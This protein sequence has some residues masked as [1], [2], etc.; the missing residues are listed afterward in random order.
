MTKRF[1]HTTTKDGE[2]IDPWK[3]K[4][5]LVDASLAQGTLEALGGITSL[6]RRGR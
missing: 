1:V 3:K 6:L 4:E 5:D 2:G